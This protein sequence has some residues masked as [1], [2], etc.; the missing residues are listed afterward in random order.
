[1]NRRAF[2]A[3]SG[4]AL[5]AAGLGALFN[6]SNAFA[7]QVSCQPAQ[8]F[9]NVYS[10]QYYSGCTQQTIDYTVTVKFLIQSCTNADGT[11]TY[12]INEQIHGTAV[13]INPQTGQPNGTQYVVN[14][15]VS[16]RVVIGPAPTGPGQCTT[17]SNTIRERIVLVSQ[18]SQP[19]ELFSGI[20]TFTISSSCGISFNFSGESVCTG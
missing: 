14:F 19:N 4:S 7:Q 17:F 10:G 13:G 20:V 3:T 15:P 9:T 5:T 12:R 2:I 6:R 16:D 18:G 8:L 11:I 1:M